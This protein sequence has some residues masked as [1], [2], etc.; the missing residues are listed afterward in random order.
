[1]NILP[2]LRTGTLTI[3]LAPHSAAEIMAALI[4]E[5]ALHGP[6]TVLD[7]GNR[8]M[9]YRIA[10][11][12]RNKSLNVEQISKR[13]ILRRAF[14]CYQVVSL[15]E[16]TH[17]FSHPHIILDLLQTF[18]DDQVSVPASRRL[19]NTCLK[20]IDRLRFAAPIVVSLA[21]A[22]ASGKPFLVDDLCAQADE[23]FVPTES[24]RMEEEQL[25]LF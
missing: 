19:L 22:P 9:A 3:A 6:V 15:L 1:M 25:V 10:K 20:E 4:A 5:L 12:I 24:L 2:S 17:A 23:V 21:P 14:T 18:H 7:A 16:G 13:I 8:F 11:L